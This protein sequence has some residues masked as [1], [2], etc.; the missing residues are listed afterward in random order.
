[1][2]IYDS[3]KHMGVEGKRDFCCYDREKRFAGMLL[4][5]ME[6]KRF[7][8]EEVESSKYKIQSIYGSDR[9]L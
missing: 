7:V 3:T 4:G 8:F 2:I 9:T 5:W 1:M 6:K